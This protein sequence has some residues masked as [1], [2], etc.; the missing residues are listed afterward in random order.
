M[1]ESMYDRRDG[2]KQY[3]IDQQRASREERDAEARAKRRYFHCTIAGRIAERKAEE[4]EKARQA[5]EK[6]E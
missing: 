2:V 6:K 1:S 4:A 5:K 3:I